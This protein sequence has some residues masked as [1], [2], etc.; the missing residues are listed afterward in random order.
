[1]VERS[2]HVSEHTTRGA[3]MGTNILYGKTKKKKKKKKQ[4]NCYTKRTIARGDLLPVV[5]YKMMIH[6]LASQTAAKLQTRGG[7]AT[8]F[9]SSH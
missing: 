8:V 4:L 9:F 3:G 1:M 6:K 7:F 2:V 5:S